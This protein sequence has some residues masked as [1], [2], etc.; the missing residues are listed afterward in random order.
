MG[1][2]YSVTVL[3]LAV[4]TTKDVNGLVVTT[5]EALELIEL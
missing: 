4:A 3:I 2:D 5:R 1:L